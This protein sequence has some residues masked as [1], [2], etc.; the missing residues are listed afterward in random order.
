MCS[1]AVQNTA[2]VCGYF[3]SKLWKV[4][5]PWKGLSHDEF[6]IL[7]WG[8]SEIRMYNP[9]KVMKYGVLVRVVCEALKRYHFIF[10]MWKNTRNW[11]NTV[12]F[13]QKYRPE[14]SH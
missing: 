9:R 7:W 3:L 4:Y 14:L 8:S 10:V 5:N 13:G 11:V 6:M 1:E 12:R 2:P